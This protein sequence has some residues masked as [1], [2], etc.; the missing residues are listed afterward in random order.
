VRN[1][2]L[3]QCIRNKT[4]TEDPY[5]VPASCKQGATYNRTK[6]YVKISG[7]ACEGGN[8]KH[9]LPDELPCPIK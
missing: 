4:T 2:G 6:G 7:D 1:L 3:K 5:A 9:F 8:E